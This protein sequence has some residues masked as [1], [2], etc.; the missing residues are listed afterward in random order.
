MKII[1]L[2][3]TT[4][5]GILDRC[6]SGL[7]QEQPI[8]R[9]LDPA[10]AEKIDAFIKLLL[11]KRKLKSTFTMVLLLNQKM[12]FYVLNTSAFR[13]LMTH[14]GTVTLRIQMLLIWTLP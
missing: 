8:R 4:V 1:H 5:E 9:V 3:I 10:S 7:E 6:I 11:E 13:L 12:F 2:E 14:Q